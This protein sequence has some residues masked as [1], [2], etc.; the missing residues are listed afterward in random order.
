MM[1]RESNAGRIMRV[2]LLTH[3]RNFFHIRSPDE[4]V[5]SKHY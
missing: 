5:A 3:C 1:S 2:E 4:N